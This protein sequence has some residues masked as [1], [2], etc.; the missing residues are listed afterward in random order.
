MVL[1]SCIMIGTMF[2]SAPAFLN[3]LRG[4]GGQFGS[5]SNNNFFANYGVMVVPLALAWTMQKAAVRRGSATFWPFVVAGGL[6]TLVLLGGVFSTTSKGGF[7]SL[8]VGLLVFA[9]AAVRAQGAA[10]GSGSA[11]IEYS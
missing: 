4:A 3:L 5:F 2:V 11:R 1:L 9:V 6:A 8:L 7:L 10:F